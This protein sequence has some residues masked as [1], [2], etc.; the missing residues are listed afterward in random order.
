MA[1][2]SPSTAKKSLQRRLAN[3][4]NVSHDDD[5]DYLSDILDQLVEMADDPEDVVA[6]LSSFVV[7]GGDVG[8]AS[9]GRGEGGAGLLEVFAGD[10]KRWKD[11]EEFE[12]ERHSDFIASAGDS[13]G[14]N[15]PSAAAA[16]PAAASSSSRGVLEDMA[17]QREEIKRRENEARERQQKEQEMWKRKKQEE[18]ERKRRA[19][20]EKQR[21][22]PDSKWGVEK[23][24]NGGGKQ[25]NKNHAQKHGTRGKQQHKLQKSASKNQAVQ[26]PTSSSRNNKQPPLMHRPQKGK[27]KKMCGCY[28]TKHE[29]LANCLHCGR[30]SCEY[31]GYD[32]CPFCENLI[33]PGDADTNDSAQAHKN[34]LLEFDRTTA[35]R[36]RIHDDQEDYFVTSTSMWSTA[37]E[38]QSAKELEE[39]RNR[40]LHTRGNQVLQL[41]L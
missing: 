27:P 16:S 39:E 6:Y 19:V 8:G 20:E 24:N 5:P 21:I 28:G 31:E 11:G 35:E 4:L 26:N 23:S 14:N 37:E 18:E 29:P 22:R 32:Y 30:I 36:T 33:I 41:D 1:T 2:S 12:M 9:D 40:K 15:L 38:Q 25:Q 13:N 34:R 17:A 3:I 10:V 7:D